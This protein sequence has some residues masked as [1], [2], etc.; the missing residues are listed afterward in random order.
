M[1]TINITAKCSDMF[2]MIL[3]DDK[4]KSIAEY[5][6]YVPS[7]LPNSNVQHYGDYIEL[8]IDVDTGMITN[9]KKPTNKQLTDLFEKEN[10]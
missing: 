6:G 4:D 10:E 8:S 9:W 7:W 2:S 3:R 5:T 1:K